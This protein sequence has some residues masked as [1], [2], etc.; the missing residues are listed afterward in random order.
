MLGFPPICFSTLPLVSFIIT[1]R[2]KHHRKY[3]GKDETAQF[4]KIFKQNEAQELSPQG[5]WG[6]RGVFEPQSSVSRRGGS[7]KP[8]TVLPWWSSG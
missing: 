5:M 4:L 2:Q 6:V 3:F 1:P 7:K 8:D